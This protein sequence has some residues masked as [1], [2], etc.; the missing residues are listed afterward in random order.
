ML[1]FFGDSFTYGHG[2]PDCLVDG[3]HAGPE[4]SR[5][6]FPTLI[7]KQTHI[8]HVNLAGPGTSNQ[9]MLYKLRTSDITAGDVAIFCWSQLNRQLIL[10]EDK[11][12]HMGPWHESAGYYYDLHDDHALRY[13]NVVTLEHATLWCAAKG[14]NQLMFSVGPVDCSESARYMLDIMRNH[15][16]DM[17]DDNKHFGMLTHMAWAD[18]ISGYVNSIYSVVATDSID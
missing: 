4:P 1:Y 9:H 8:P 3:E 15:E 18:V 7:S 2:L 5:L 10:R 13:D 6:A 16:L 11:P 14:I 12:I 17:A